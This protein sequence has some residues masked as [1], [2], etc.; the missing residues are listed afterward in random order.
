MST[1]SPSHEFKQFI[2]LTRLITG[3]SRLALRGNLNEPSSVTNVIASSKSAKLGA[4]NTTAIVT[5]IPVAKSP[6]VSLGYLTRD[7]VNTSDEG[8]TNFNLF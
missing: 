4:W 3:G 2:G 5:D 8:G 7:T 1:R 6:E